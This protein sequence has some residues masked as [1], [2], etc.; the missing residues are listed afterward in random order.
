[1]MLRVEL[2]QALAC[3]VR[4]DLRGRNVGMAQEQ[5]NDPKIRTVVEKM[6]FE[7]VPQRMRRD[8]LRDSGA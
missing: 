7:R 8:W 6:R 5:L 3:D 2:L 4:V 1:M